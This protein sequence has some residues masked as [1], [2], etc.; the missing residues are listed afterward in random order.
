MAV[1]EVNGEVN[2]EV[3]GDGNGHLSGDM[4]DSEPARVSGNTRPFFFVAT[5]K[6]LALAIGLRILGFQII[7]IRNINTSRLG[8]RAST[9][10]KRPCGSAGGG[11]LSGKCLATL[12]QKPQGCGWICWPV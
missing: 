12:G 5:A 1:G 3:D 8:C 11:G 10:A 9:S 7:Q 6:I 2:G 4:H